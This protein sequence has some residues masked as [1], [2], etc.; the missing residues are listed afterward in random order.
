M[1]S[2]RLEITSDQDPYLAT[3]D[4]RSGETT[5]LRMPYLDKL[6]M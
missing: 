2:D 5:E 3:V 1:F 4:R 6:E